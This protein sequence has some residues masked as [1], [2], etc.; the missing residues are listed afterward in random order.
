MPKLTRRK[1]SQVRFCRN[2]NSHRM[3]PSMM[4]VGTKVARNWAVHYTREGVTSET[5]LVIQS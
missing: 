4:R 2:L 5:V 1:I 3:I